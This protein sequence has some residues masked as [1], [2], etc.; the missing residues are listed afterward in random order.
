MILVAQAGLMIP[1]A[2]AGL[3][4]PVAQ[5]GLMIPV[6]QAGLTIPVAQAGLMIPVVPVN[7]GA[8]VNQAARRVQG[9]PVALGVQAK[10]PYNVS[11]AGLEDVESLQSGHC[12]VGRRICFPKTTHESP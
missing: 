7:Q 2:R 6:A 8:Q 11:A 5:A 12:R 9:E 4:I 1:V 10:L 3:M